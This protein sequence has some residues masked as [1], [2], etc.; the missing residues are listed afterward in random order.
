MQDVI[1]VESDEEVNATLSALT[2]IGYVCVTSCGLSVMQDAERTLIFLISRR[3]VFLRDAYCYRV[4]ASV[5][6]Y[7]YRLLVKLHTSLAY[8]LKW[9]PL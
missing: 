8:L 6:L 1:L 5:F 4:Q 7:K 9:M 2:E 3:R